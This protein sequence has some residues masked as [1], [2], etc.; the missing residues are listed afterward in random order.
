MWK[1]GCGRDRRP[2]CQQFSTLELGIDIGTIDEVVLIG[3]PPTLTS[4]LQRIGRGG[5]RT[6][7]TRVLCLARSP[8]EE[9]RFLALLVLAQDK[10][11]AAVSNVAAY[12]FRPAVLVNKRSA[13]SNK[14]PLE[15]APDRFA[16]HRPTRCAG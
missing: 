12:H 5:R 10:N 2:L 3:P 4:F 9:L 14:A 7:E 13:C 11:Q 6:G 16:P 8:L 1:P 15:R